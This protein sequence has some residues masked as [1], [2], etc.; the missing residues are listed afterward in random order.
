[1]PQRME[2]CCAAE[3]AVDV[4]GVVALEGAEEGPAA[5]RLAEGGEDAIQEIGGEVR[6]AIRR[7]GVCGVS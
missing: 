7:H 1:M 3:F 5:G 2:G 4:T 6:D